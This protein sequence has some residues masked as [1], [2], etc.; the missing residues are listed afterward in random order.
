MRCGK[1]GLGKVIF[2]VGFLIFDWGGGPYY[3]QSR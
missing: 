2:D 3:A 1:G